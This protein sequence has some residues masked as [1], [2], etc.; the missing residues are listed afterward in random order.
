MCAAAVLIAAELGKKSE[1][2][3][4][5]SCGNSNS[6]IL[7][8]DNKEQLPVDKCSKKKPHSQFLSVCGGELLKFIKQ[9]KF[10]LFGDSDTNVIF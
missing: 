4:Q 6:R 1:A 7:L 10:K 2:Q 8:T 3:D 5:I 9:F